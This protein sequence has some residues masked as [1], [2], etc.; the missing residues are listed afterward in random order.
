MQDLINW[1]K[2]PSDSRVY[3]KNAMNNKHPYRTH[4]HLFEFDSDKFTSTLQ[5]SKEF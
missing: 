5:K 3:P 4:A 2:L 1:F